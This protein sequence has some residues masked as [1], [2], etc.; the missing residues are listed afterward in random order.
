MRIPGTGLRVTESG[1]RVQ[2][3]KK[4]IEK[5]SEDTGQPVTTIPSQQP[6]EVATSFISI[7]HVRR[8]IQKD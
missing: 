6:H 8:E 7:L 2:K 4:Y 5:K 3:K 1:R